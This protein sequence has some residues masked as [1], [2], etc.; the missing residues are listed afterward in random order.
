M[1]LQFSRT[2]SFAFLFMVFSLG[3][4]L[5][6]FTFKV[7]C[8]WCLLGYFRVSSVF[9]SFSRFFYV[10]LILS[11]IFLCL[12][13]YGFLPVLF[14][15]FFSLCSLSVGVCSVTIWALRSSQYR[16]KLSGTERRQWW[17]CP[18]PPSQYYHSACAPPR[19]IRVGSARA[20]RHYSVTHTLPN[21]MP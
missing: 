9:L 1:Y 16:M 14:L 2:S 11:D 7:S 19:A 15:P 20:T 13:V 6:F 10:S 18:D 3:S 17:F 5:P 8:C 12:T 21:R 4:F